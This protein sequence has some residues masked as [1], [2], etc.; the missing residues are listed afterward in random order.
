MPTQVERNK[1][2]ADLE[3][4]EKVLADAL[5]GDGDIHITNYAK[6]IA[7]S[8]CCGVSSLAACVGFL[9]EIVRRNAMRSDN[10]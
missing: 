5:A 1:A 2:I 6:T 10:A 4:A 8:P 3:A 7:K 9:R